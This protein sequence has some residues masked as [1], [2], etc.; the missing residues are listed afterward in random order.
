MDMRLAKLTRLF[1][2]FCSQYGQELRTDKQNAGNLPGWWYGYFYYGL[3]GYLEREG[4]NDDED[5]E[6]ICPPG[7]FPIMSIHQAKGLEFDFVF[8]GNLGGKPFGNSAQR[9]ESDLRRFRG[10]PPAIVHSIEA[11]QSHDDIRL[12]Y[13]AYS[14]AKYALALAAA[15][16]QLNKKI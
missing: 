15:N 2:A 5:E 4:M 1:E 13:V 14:R 3:F 12:Y 9:L 7:K 8:V 10:N 16:S 11:S 6:V